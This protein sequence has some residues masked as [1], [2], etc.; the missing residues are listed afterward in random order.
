MLSQQ[1]A[2]RA[3]RCS[4]EATSVIPGRC[5]LLNWASGPESGT[6]LKREGFPGEPLPL[7]IISLPDSFGQ[8]QPPQAWPWE[9][10]VASGFLPLAC[11]WS[12][13]AP[14]R[15]WAPISLSWPRLTGFCPHLNTTKR[16]PTRWNQLTHLAGPWGFKHYWASKA[17]QQVQRCQPSRK[18]RGMEEIRA[19]TGG[20][21][22]GCAPSRWSLASPAS[23]PPGLC[24]FIL[25]P[26]RRPR[27]HPCSEAGTRCCHFGGCS[28]FWSL[29]LSKA[30]AAGTKSCL[31]VGPRLREAPWWEDIPVGASPPP[32][33]TCRWEAQVHRGSGF[34]PGDT[35][36]ALSLGTIKGFFGSGS[37]TS[38][39]EALCPNMFAPT[40]LIKGKELTDRYPDRQH[41]GG[42]RLTM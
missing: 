40:R 22:M 34:M 1:C 29:E 2:H 9:L 7:E 4:P 35:P 5:G 3:A 12:L 8:E 21:H 39:K 14:A 28:E 6:W 15:D 33:S 13:R 37:P 42:W 18:G 30:E 10:R 16:D 17:T 19:Y 32:K 27:L 20:A 41:G 36:S 26:T 38:I 31:G 23:G 25:R 11:W 24:K